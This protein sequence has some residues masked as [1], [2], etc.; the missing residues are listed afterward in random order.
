MVCS[1]P[2]ARA[3]SAQ[4]IRCDVLQVLGASLELSF[5]MAIYV[6]HESRV[7]CPVYCESYPLGRWDFAASN[8]YMVYLYQLVLIHD[9]LWNANV[10]LR[11]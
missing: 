8:P 11:G 5:R 1:G 2:I 3:T 4:P 9:H 10:A 6:R 7:S